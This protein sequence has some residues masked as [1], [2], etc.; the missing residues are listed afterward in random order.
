MRSR[1]RVFASVMML[2]FTGSWVLA[3][4]VP[5]TTVRGAEFA[6]A[7][8]VM[9]RNLKLEGR[10]FVPQSV[11]RARGAIVFMTVSVFPDG[12]FGVAQEAATA[13]PSL[14]ARLGAAVLHVRVSNIVRPAGVVAPSEEVARNAAIGGS[15]ALL[16]LLERLADESGHRELREAPLAFWGFS[17]VANFGTVFA[18]LYP[19]RT[20]AVVRYHSH[21]REMSIDETRLS[22]VPV[23]LLAGGADRRAGMEDAESL[24]SRGKASGAPWTLAVDSAATHWDEASLQRANEVFIPWMASV[25]RQRVP[26]S[27]TKLRVVDGTDGWLGDRRTATAAPYGV[28]A[29]TKGEAV[30][31]PDGATARAWQLQNEPGK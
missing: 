17:A 31:L 11:E 24:W 18:T 3:Q 16:S 25:F 27:G 21:L 1:S 15:D 9:K 14:A 19:E 29:G 6:A 30:W 8:N 20:V 4:A 2:A 5:P 7:V 28:F 13:W 26:S 22:R 23:L 12:Y 10:L